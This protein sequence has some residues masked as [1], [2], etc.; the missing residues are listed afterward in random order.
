MFALQSL[1]T[2]QFIGAH[3]PLT[4]LG[5]F[6]CLT[7]QAIDVFNL[8]IEVLIRSGCQPVADQMWLK[9]AR[10]LKALPRAEGRYHRQY[11]VA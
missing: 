9:I 11:R 4:L 7:I 10:F 5:Q 8:L 6:W 2:A 3:G 1:N